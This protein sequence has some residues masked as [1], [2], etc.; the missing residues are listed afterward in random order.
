[1]R[2]SALFFASLFALVPPAVSA[3]SGSF[4]VALRGKSVGTAS[5]HI[6]PRHAGLL[7]ESTLRVSTKG[8][9]YALSK[10]EQ[11]SATHQ[12]RQ[13]E[14]NAVVNGSAVHLLA[15]PEGSQLHLAVAANGRT[16]NARFTAHT[17]AVLLPDFDPGALSTLLALYA[18]RNGRD[19]WA[20]IPRNSGAVESLTVAAYP[21]E[22]GTLDGKPIAVRHFV[23]T[24]AG[25]TTHLFAGPGNQLL[26]AELPQPGFALVRKG[27]VLTPPAHAPAPPAD[28]PAN[29]TA[30]AEKS[31][32]NQ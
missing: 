16:T 3:Q 21:D 22:K 14:L 1:M 2:L 17:G 20:V 4:D 23:V 29:S 24:C 28:A 5:F 27:F 9:E 25:T 19:L 10:S 15:T 12:L 8:I 30:P 6:V 32:Q 13:A 7:S 18:E 31:S 11:L 26:Q